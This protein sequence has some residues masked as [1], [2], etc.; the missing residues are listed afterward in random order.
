MKLIE[1]NFVLFNSLKSIIWVHLLSFVFV[2]PLFP[3]KYEIE[4]HKGLKRAKRVERKIYEFWGGLN[5]FW[6]LKPILYTYLQTQVALNGIRSL[7]GK[8]NENMPSCLVIT[9]R[10]LGR[11]HSAPK[12]ADEVLRFIFKELH[13]L[14]F[15]GS[16]FY[17]CFKIVNVIEYEGLI[18]ILPAAW[19]SEVCT[20]LSLNILEF[21]MELI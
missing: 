4:G 19:K 17:L 5:I 10:N 16:E 18:Y 6:G 21:K 9:E 7:K 12:L 14:A 13:F 20:A 1:I 8:A 11:E 2:E 15:V 3:E